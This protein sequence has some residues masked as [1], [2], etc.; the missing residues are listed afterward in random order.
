MHVKYA[1]VFPQ[2]D[3]ENDETKFLALDKCLPHRDFL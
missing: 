2:S 1:A 3:K